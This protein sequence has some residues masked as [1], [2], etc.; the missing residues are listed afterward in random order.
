[1]LRPVRQICSSTAE[2]ARILIHRSLSSFLSSPLS[3]SLSLPLL[4]LFA[5]SS[6]TRVAVP[7]TRLQAR[8]HETARRHLTSPPSDTQRRRVRR[9][10]FARLLFGEN[11]TRTAKCASVP[12]LLPSP[13]PPS[14]SPTAARAAWIKAAQTKPRP[15][16]FGDPNFHARVQILGARRLL[17]PPSSL[18][19]L[20]HVPR[21]SK[22]ASARSI[23]FRSRVASAPALFL[24]YATAMFERYMFERATNT[25]VTA[26]EHARACACS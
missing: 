7:A 16:G 13:P 6:N 26:Y 1:M 19:P 8:V 25:G 17:L 18:Q 2:C 12:R 10:G 11:Y 4:F 21:V 22:R 15:R 23:K 14:H 3:L 5:S 24:S 9:N 20:W